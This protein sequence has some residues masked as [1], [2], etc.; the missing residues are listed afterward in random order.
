MKAY[1]L[2][3]YFNLDKVKRFGL[4]SGMPTKYDHVGYGIY[5][6]FDRRYADDIQEY[7]GLGNEDDLGR[8]L[9]VEVDVDPSDLLMDED[10]L[11]EYDNYLSK[12]LPKHIYREYI[13]MI[14]EYGCDD[15]PINEPELG[16][17]KTEFIVRHQLR[18]NPKL[19]TSW[20]HYSVLTARCNTDRLHAQIISILFDGDQYT[21][22]EFANLGLL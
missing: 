5:V 15:L 2:T 11:I 21:E 19:K 16:K 4:R 13:A 17:A 12:I 8:V 1:H 22:E 14:K 18:P 20:G 9:L 10:A 3:E 7:L 6:F